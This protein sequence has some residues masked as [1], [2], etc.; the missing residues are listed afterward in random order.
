[1]WRWPL[2][3]LTLWGCATLVCCICGAL[4]AAHEPLVALCGLCLLIIGIVFECTLSALLCC[5][6]ELEDFLCVGISIR[7]SR[8]GLWCNKHESSCEA[9]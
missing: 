7:S 6:L 3:L 5:V 4:S 2:L 1:M 8:I 9:C